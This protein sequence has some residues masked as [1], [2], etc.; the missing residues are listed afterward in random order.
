ME[1]KYYTC[2]KKNRI[3]QNKFGF[4]EQH[5]TIEQVYRIVNEIKYTPEEKKYSFAV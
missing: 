4:H 2:K 3:T 5:N 1:I